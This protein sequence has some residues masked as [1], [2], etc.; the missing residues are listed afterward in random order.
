LDSS[1][2]RPA[3]SVGRRDFGGVVFVGVVFVGV[4]DGEVVNDCVVLVGPSAVWLSEGLSEGRCFLFLSVVG[5]LLLRRGEVGLR[6]SGK[7]ALE[8][9]D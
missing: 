4:V 6:L 9:I 3:G 2:P 1:L 8:S 7:G 5:V